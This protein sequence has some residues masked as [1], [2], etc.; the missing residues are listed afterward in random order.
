M[1]AGRILPTV[2]AASD[3]EAWPTQRV[4][5]G[6]Q[7]DAVRAYGT[8]AAQAAMMHLSIEED[9]MT[10]RTERDTDQEQRE[11]EAAEQEPT[12]DVEGETTVPTSTSVGGASGIGMGPGA[13]ATLTDMPT[14]GGAREAERRS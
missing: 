2:H 5:C 12:P 3:E 4:H 11:E 1:Q 7:S 13:A 6:R 9:A 8:G 10:E 14:G